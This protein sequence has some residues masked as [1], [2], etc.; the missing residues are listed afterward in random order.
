MVQV[1]Y[2]DVLL[3]VDFSMNCFALYITAYFIR[4][5]IK[6]ACLVVAALIGGIYHVAAVYLNTD[7]LLARLTVAAVGLLMCYIAF[8]SYRFVR[9]VLVFFAVSMLIGGLMYGVYFLFGSYHS[10]LFG[11]SRGY[12]YTHI[13]L[14]MFAALAAVS[15]VLALV[16]SRLG[17]DVT[18]RRDVTVTVTTASGCKV[19]HLLLDSGNL[20]REP[21]SG[22]Y[23]VIVG[24]SAVDSLLPETERRALHDR[25]TET[26][27]RRRFRLICTHGVDGAP[28]TLFGFLPDSIVYADGKRAVRLDAYIAVSQTETAFCG[29]EGI[30]HPSAIG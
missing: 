10:D 20:V 19:L 27:L 16:F 3:L 6:A 23:V 18:D 8:G 24:E 2:G 14:W 13:P 25:D 12:A 28:R 26:L 11:N 5:H 17:R 15:F 9:S 30:V 22:K 1:I 21:I 4:R 7:N 29:F